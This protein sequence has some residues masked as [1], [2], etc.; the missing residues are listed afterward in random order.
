MK[1]RRKMVQLELPER[2]W[3][4]RRKGAGRPKVKGVVLH[5]RRPKFPGRFPLHITLRIRREVGSLRSERR[6]AQIKTA[7]RHGCDQFGMRLVEF[8][9]QSNH[10]HLIVEAE[11]RE[12]LSRGM[13]ALAIRLAR[14]VNRASGRVGTVFADRYF[15]RILK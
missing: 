5:R 14:A 1:R 3:G 4:G 15:A 12:A 10:I 13:Q 8:S 6:F 11:N 9:V 2:R 7:F